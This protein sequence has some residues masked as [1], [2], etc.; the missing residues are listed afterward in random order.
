M[1]GPQLQSRTTRSRQPQWAWPVFLLTLLTLA[2]LTASTQQA[3]AQSR[4]YKVEIIVFDEPGAPAY[5]EESW[6]DNPGQPD[7]SGAVELGG[8]DGL[9][10]VDGDS[11]PGA[12]RLV[13]SSGFS[14]RGVYTR[15]DRSGQFRP[16]GHMAWHQPGYSR[17]NARPAHVVVYSSGIDSSGRRGLVPIVDGTVS[18][19]RG[20]F[21]HTEVDLLYQPD[22]EAYRLKVSRKMRSNELHYIDHPLFGVLIRVSPI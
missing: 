20:R 14:L 13:G 11:R 12:F 21:L 19:S 4:W 7:L 5:A 15:L 17:R 16:L 2:A 6:P 10:S 3:A 18:L 22:G 8:G 1:S 9:G